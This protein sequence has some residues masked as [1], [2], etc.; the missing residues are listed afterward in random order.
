MSSLAFYPSR[1]QYKNARTDTEPTKLMEYYLS[2]DQFMRPWKVYKTAT[3]R[4]FRK[5]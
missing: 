4:F 2:M 1:H 3:T 5:S